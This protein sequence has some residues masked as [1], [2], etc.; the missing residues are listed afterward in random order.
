VVAALFLEI[1]I[2][3]QDGQV[4]PRAYEFMR[5]HEPFG[6]LA[7]T[8]NRCNTQFDPKLFLNTLQAS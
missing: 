1:G 7:T 8:W 6:S 2:L 5:S 3:F 4:T